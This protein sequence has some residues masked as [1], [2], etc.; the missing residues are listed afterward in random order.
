MSA[1][2]KSQRQAANSFAYSLNRASTAIEVYII[3]GIIDLPKS[4]LA[5]LSW[6]RLNL[7]LLLQELCAFGV[8]TGIS[9][10]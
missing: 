4:R 1:C 3:K 9:R 6:Y 7:I 2:L 8:A 10:D 5:G